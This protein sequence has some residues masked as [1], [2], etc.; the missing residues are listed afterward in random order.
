MKKSKFLTAGVLALV[1]AFS[2]VLVGCDDST[3]D[4]N[5]NLGNNN[6]GTSTPG[7]ND[8]G[9]NNSG[10][11]NSG[12]NNP[13]NTT[14]GGTQVPGRVWGTQV[15][16]QSSSSIRITW[17]TVAGATS[18]NVYFIRGTDL[19]VPRTLAGTVTDTSYTHTGLPAST[20]H[21]YIVTALNSAGEGPGPIPSSTGTTVSRR[22]EWGGGG[23]TVTGFHQAQGGG[24]LGVWVLTRNPATFE[25]FDSARNTSAQIS[26]F[27]A[28]SNA[29]NLYNWG[30]PL[31]EGDA[32]PPDGTYTIIVNTRGN[33]F[34]G[35][36][37]VYRFTNITV[38]GG[39]ATV[40]FNTVVGSLVGSNGRLR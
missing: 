26:Q 33:S 20:F 30:G 31:T 1:L 37:E 7:N 34:A 13:G 24:T 36:A 21:T 28:N 18:Y 22:T 12:A 2:F 6:P 5:N 29:A 23:L 3:D 39:T 10:D 17:D 38:T 8:P 15:V 32:A 25:E 11:N 16:V 40:P 19:T 35:N 14:T 4:G 9:T 27:I